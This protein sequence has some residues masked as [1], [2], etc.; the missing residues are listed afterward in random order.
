MEWDHWCN[1]K[2]LKDILPSFKF[3]KSFVNCYTS[4]YGWN[5]PS[6]TPPLLLTEMLDINFYEQPAVVWDGSL[7]PTFSTF[8]DSYFGL[9]DEVCW[10]KFVWHK[11]KSLRFSSYAWMAMLGKLKTADILIQRGIDAYVTCSFC[12]AGSDC[13]SHLFFSCDFSF[14]V[15]ASLLP[16][17]GSFLFRPNL[18]QTFEFFEEARD[19]SIGEKNFCYFTI[20]SSIYFLWRERNT[21][22]FENN[23]KSPMTLISVIRHAI[24]AKVKFW[25]QFED[26]KR[27]FDFLC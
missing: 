24:L 27:R 14:T 5:L 15:I 26:L 10:H 13:H 16:P 21:R 3:E 17:L 7:S 4:N 1:G 23:W 19:F 22:R 12:G 25:K 11:K 9:N 2:S 18:L 6:S 20:C 8:Y